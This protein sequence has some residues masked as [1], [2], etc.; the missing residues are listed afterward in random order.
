MFV[1]FGY[2]RQVRQLAPVLRCHCYRCQRE[3][4]W[5]LWKETEWVSFFMIRTIP[6]VSRT[7]LVCPTCGSELKVPAA[8]S[9][10][11]EARQDVRELTHAYEEAQLADKNEVQ[12]TWL[13]SQRPPR[14]GLDA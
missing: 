6:F 4:P 11:L 14:A 2:A 12:R 13:R 10:R 1:M 3:R 5:E 8:Q 9:R 7:T